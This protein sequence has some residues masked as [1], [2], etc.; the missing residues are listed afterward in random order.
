[1]SH[2]FTVILV[3]PDKEDIRAAVTE[4]LTPFD[5]NTQ[6]EPYKKRLTQE[7][8]DRMLAFYAEHPEH[9]DGLTLDNVVGLL[10]KYHE[11]EAGQDENGYYYVS[12]YNPKS[13]W[14]WWRIGGRY[15]GRVAAVE[16]DSENGF[17]FDKAHESLDLNVRPVRDLPED[18]TCWAILT[19]DGQWHQKAKMGWFGMAANEDEGWL[20]RMRRIFAE[21]NECVAV[22]CD[23]HI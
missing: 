15:D 18:F 11:A 17:N 14:D 20:P 4:M 13:Q 12:T 21:N 2:F 19:P 6:V 3:P 23:L 5:E 10:R 9:R 16:H 7:S 22:G 1:M 8:I